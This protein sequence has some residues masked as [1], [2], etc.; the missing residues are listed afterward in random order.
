MAKGGIG[1]FVV[2][3]AAPAECRLN[4]TSLRSEA[5]YERPDGGDLTI[6]ASEVQTCE[7]SEELAKSGVSIT[8]TDCG[9]PPENMDHL[10]EPLFTTKARGIG[11]GLALSKN[12]VEANEGSIEVES[13]EGKGSRFTLRLPTEGIMQ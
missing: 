9:I 13:R 8:D 4:A 2:R 5:N 10:F 12:L 7:A 6:E 1:R 11:L 3:H